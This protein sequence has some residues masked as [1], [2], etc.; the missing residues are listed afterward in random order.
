MSRTHLH[1]DHTDRSMVGVNAPSSADFDV[2][3][4]ALRDALPRRISI[5]ERIDF[6]T[7]YKNIIRR[8][9]S[10]KAIRNRRDAHP[11]TTEPQKFRQHVTVEKK[12]TRVGA[13]TNLK[14]LSIN[15]L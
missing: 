4:D 15:K 5:S 14:E 3:R 2:R 1:T 10:P 8:P 13:P 7:Y 9:H 11:E 12:L 6:S